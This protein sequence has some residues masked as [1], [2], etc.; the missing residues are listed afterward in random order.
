MPKSFEVNPSELVEK[1]AGELKKESEI[2]TPDWAGFVKT[3]MHKER[4]PS[5]EWWH[6]R[7]ASMLRTVAKL[8]PIGV[9]KLKIKYGGKKNRGHKP[10]HFYKG[11]GS[12]ARKTLQ[13]LEKAGLVKQATKGTHK[14]RVI[15]KKAAELMNYIAKD[16]GA[17]KSADKKTATPAKV[18]SKDNTPTQK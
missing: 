15:T 7:A 4:P 5:K 1:V 9:S 14:G 16:L 10:S 11:S 8:G 17:T 12:I 2:K 13:Q 6:M 3:G 18:E